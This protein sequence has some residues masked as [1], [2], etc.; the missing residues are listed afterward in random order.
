[1]PDQKPVLNYLPPDPSARQWM[2]FRRIGG[3]IIALILGVLGL[4]STALSVSQMWLQY[5]Y[6]KDYEV[7]FREDAVY[8]VFGLALVL[9]SARL[10]AIAIRSKPRATFF[11][12]R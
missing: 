6:P 8:F 1:M 2:M 11:N 12:R 7:E 3:T 5:F 10:L 4:A 9:L